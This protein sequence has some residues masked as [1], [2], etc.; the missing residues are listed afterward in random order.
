M[1]E[2]QQKPD[3]R[4]RIRSWT[5]LLLSFFF[6]WLFGAYIGPW[7]QTKIPTMDKIVEVIDE[8]DINSNGYFYTE[9][10]ESYEAEQYI[11]ESLKTSDPKYVQITL[12]FISGI[13]ICIFLLCLGF[14]Y[15]PVD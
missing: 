12:P 8:R 13:A 6:I 10:E 4:K 14:K 15:L 1:D 9:V 3:F 2:P 11:R 7:I 5:L